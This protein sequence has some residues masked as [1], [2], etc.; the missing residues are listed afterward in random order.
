MPALVVFFEIEQFGDKIR[1][2]VAELFFR[3]LY[4]FSV[5]K[6]I[7]ASLYS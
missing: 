2:A 3:G 1:V 5:Y 4:L 7:I 6:D